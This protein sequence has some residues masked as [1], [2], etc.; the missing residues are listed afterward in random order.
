MLDTTVV[1][2]RRTYLRYDIDNGCQ[3]LILLIE[4]FFQQL[5]TPVTYLALI[6]ASQSS[7][8]NNLYFKVK[9][10]NDS[11]A[12]FYNKCRVSGW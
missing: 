10:N 6:F 5:N 7:Q 4:F 2:T 8:F 3:V 9:L 1:V 11:S 12:E